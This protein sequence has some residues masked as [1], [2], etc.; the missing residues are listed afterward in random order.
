MS[1]RQH[2]FT[3][4]KMNLKRCSKKSNLNPKYKSN[5]KTEYNK[6]KYWKYLS[7]KSNV[8]RLPKT[9]QIEEMKQRYENMKNQTKGITIGMFK[10]YF[11]LIE[12]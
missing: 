3:A 7:R 2:G 6:L 4:K 9:L 12:M 10:T 1:H 11:E 8:R 5:L